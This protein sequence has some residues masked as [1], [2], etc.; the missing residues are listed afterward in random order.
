MVLEINEEIYLYTFAGEDNFGSE[1]ANRGKERTTYL[2]TLIHLPYA[3][4]ELTKQGRRKGQL[5]F[6]R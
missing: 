6:H 3:R 5:L 1:K 4:A 2:L